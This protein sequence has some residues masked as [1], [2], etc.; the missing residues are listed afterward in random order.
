MEEKIILND[1]FNHPGA[2]RHPSLEGNYQWYQMWDH[3]SPLCLPPMKSAMPKWAN[4]G[5]GAFRG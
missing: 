2:L 3:N 5:G 4:T 1:A